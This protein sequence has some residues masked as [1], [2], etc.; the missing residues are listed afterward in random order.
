V[1]ADAVADE[2][3]GL[4]PA[5]FT[6]ARDQRVREARAEGDAEAA[7]QIS[8]L[9]KPATA[10]WLANL[11]V[12]ADRDEADGLLQL[13]AELRGAQQRLD[14]E[15]MRRLSSQRQKV[16]S[17]L[18]RR[19][20]R[21]A[22][23][24]IGQT[25]ARQ[26]EDTLRA[27]LADPDAADAFAAGRL[28]APLQ[29]SGLGPAGAHL[30][31]VPNR[32]D[33]APSR[34]EAPTRTAPGRP[35]ARSKTGTKDGTKTR[36]A[37]KTGP[38]PEQRR[39]ERARHELDQ[40]RKAADSADATLAEARGQAEEAGTKRDELRAQVEQLAAAL[41]QARNAEAGAALDARQARRAVQQA[42]RAA[43]AARRR[44]AER[45]AAVARLA[46]S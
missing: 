28:T 39:L 15:E 36:P 23:Q 4:T 37:G 1:D 12:R 17:A 34:S 19:A 18:V 26:L 3:Y 33:A 32:A 29:H 35:A 10:A 21:L 30:R 27:V 38:T 11:L 31:L 43:H 9:R 41:E 5:E 8:A 13:G 46:E 44:V 25:P 42:E 24:P 45:E 6:A 14:G 20:V 40:A 2:L 16:I 7:K 22:G